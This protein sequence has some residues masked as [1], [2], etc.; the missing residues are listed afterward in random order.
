M[1]GSVSTA[2]IASQLLVAVLAAA[3]AYYA[4][5]LRSD[6]RIYDEMIQELRKH[7]GEKINSVNNEAQNQK[8]DR[9]DFQQ[10]LANTRLRRADGTPDEWLEAIKHNTEEERSIRLLRAAHQRFPGSLKIA[11]A[12]LQEYEQAATPPSELELRRQAVIKMRQ[13]V[14]KLLTACALEDFDEALEL[15]QKVDEIAERLADE[16]DERRR[17]ETVEAVKSLKEEANSLTE[18]DIG[19]ETLD[20]IAELDDRIDQEVLKQ[21]TELQEQYEEAT[22][23]ITEQ[24]SP[25]GEEEYDWDYNLNAVEAAEEVWEVFKKEKDSWTDQT[26]E[27][28]EKWRRKANPFEREPIE[29]GSAKKRRIEEIAYTLGGWDSQKLLPAVNTY[30]S[31]VHSEIFQDLDREDRKTMT[32]KM[33]EASAKS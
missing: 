30:I 29:L 14:Q 24:I 32:V 11:E 22:A 10:L 8:L 13:V 7:L 4:H 5:S 3:A 21:Q 16:M 33:I 18:S 27:K 26:K 31:S 12:L 28:L 17:E 6:L 2:L 25:N 19:D 15:E 1:I 23:A 20:E 9:S